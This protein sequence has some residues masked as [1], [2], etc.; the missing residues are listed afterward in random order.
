[1]GVFLE[2]NKPAR[3]QF[4]RTRRAPVS[5]AIVVHTAE[6]VPDV[7]GLDGGAEGVASFIARRT[8]AAG[9]YHSIVDSDSVVQLGEY[10]W[11]MFGEGTGGN[12]WCLHLSFATQASRWPNLPPG[13][14]EGALRQ[15][16]REAAR[17]ALWVES[18]IGIMV[19]AE[20]I[21]ADAY[22]AKAPGFISHGAI[23]PGRRSDPGSGFPWSRFLEMF[24]E[25]IQ[26]MRPAAD[27]EI[28]EDM[29]ELIVLSDWTAFDARQ[30]VVE[31]YRRHR[32]NGVGAWTP[33][34]IDLWMADIVDKIYHPT[35]QHN[36]VET[37]RYIH[38]ALGAET[39]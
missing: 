18:E 21:T 37:F 23:D 16:A 5:G 17:M 15:G 30:E 10:S 24:A 27:D 4:R 14:V 32:G 9:S 7:E 12:R 3:S 26:T 2:D 39:A 36:L 11:E 8:D 20:Q 29:D 13:W 22:R 34:E 35:E 31:I 28:P 38:W 33:S 6:S 19:P 1:M 25:E